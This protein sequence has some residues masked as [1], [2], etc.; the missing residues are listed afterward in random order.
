MIERLHNNELETSKKIRSVFQVS[1]KIEAELL[2][3]T[4]FPPLKRPLEDYVKS[5]TDFYGYSK[6]EVLVGLLKLII[7]IPIP[8]SVV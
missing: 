6:N 3:A 2:K 5:N 4:N 8:I 7:I 1:Y